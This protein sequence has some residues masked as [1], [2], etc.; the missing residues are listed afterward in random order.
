M[1]RTQQPGT[2]RSI[3]LSTE[4]IARLE[5]IGFEWEKRDDTNEIEM[6]PTQEE[7]NAIFDKHCC[8]LEAFKDIHGHCNVPHRY[9]DNPALG[10]WSSHMRRAYKEIQLGLLVTRKLSPERIQHL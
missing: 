5:E 6:G 2:P 3:I 1:Y 4:R 9:K 10:S 8:D 7:N